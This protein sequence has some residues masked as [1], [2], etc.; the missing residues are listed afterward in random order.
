MY[1]FFNFENGKTRKR[2]ERVTRSVGRLAKAAWRLNKPP[3]IRSTISEAK[4]SLPRLSCGLLL[5][6]L[7]IL[8]PDTFAQH[9]RDRFSANSQVGAPDWEIDQ[10]FKHD[11]FTF[12]RVKYD[13]YGGGR[14]GWGRG[15]W[16]TDYP[17][18]ELNLAYRLQ[19][20]TSLKVN[21]DSAVVV[22]DEDDLSNYPFLY[23]V[24]PGQGQ[25]DLRATE[26]EALRKYL[27][28]GGFLMVDDFWGEA[29]WSVLAYEMRRVFPDREPIELPIE[30]PIFHIVFDL[31]EKPQIPSLYHAVS[32]RG[33]GIT[34]ERHDAQEVHYKGIFD[35]Q[36]RLMVII[37]HN[38]DLGDGWERE[39]ES[40]WYFREFAEKKAYP[41]GI[42]IIVY[43]MTH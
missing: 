35:D 30:H 38:T 21:P 28:N 36:G 24:E 33:T 40:V 4:P 11:V 16:A 41:L 13:S 39:G 23:M 1:R 20:M 22:L 32:N 43:A 26:V 34:W 7:A 3:Y 6:A 12:A 17:D 27:L 14:P 25:L 18:A 31:K 5:L 2:Y 37:C 29:E 10:K 19:Q 9:R 8:L 15:Y 42:N